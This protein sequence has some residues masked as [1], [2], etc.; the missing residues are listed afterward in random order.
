MTW[1][2]KIILAV[3]A[4]VVGFIFYRTAVRKILFH[5]T[6]ARQLYPKLRELGKLDEDYVKRSKIAVI[7][8]IPV[9]LI[10]LAAVL[11]FAPASVKIY[12]PCGLLMGFL[13][14]RKNLYITK[15]TISDEICKFSQYPS[16]SADD[17]KYLLTDNSSPAF[18]DKFIYTVNV[19]AGFIPLV[20]LFV[21]ASYYAF[22]VWP[23]ADTIGSPFEDSEPHL[24][25]YNVT[26][27]SEKT[28]NFVVEGRAEI[29]AWYDE[30]E[31]DMFYSI[32]SISLP[33]ENGGTYTL[34]GDQIPVKIDEVLD[35]NYFKDRHGVSW[36]IKLD[37]NIGT[38]V[39][40]FLA[41]IIL[42]VVLF[43]IIIKIEC[44][45][46]ERRDLEDILRGN[47]AMF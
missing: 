9:S 32:T 3:L 43:F 44:S 38:T 45:A 12:F 6:G 7:S 37:Y 41:L 2:G 39:L 5:F 22:F 34:E 15:D 21:V 8:L 19:T 25:T 1:K 4:F 23:G 24:V 11:V 18:Y 36:E 47:P 33:Q 40:K 30:A 27:S 46:K 28:K 16:L 42:F 31:E 20:L 10:T 13:T 35:V 29:F 26:A 17:Y 14:H